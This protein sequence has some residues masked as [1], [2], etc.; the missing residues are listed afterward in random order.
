MAMM[1]V[2][3]GVAL[4]ADAA[5]TTT[6]DDATASAAS[7]KDQ[8][9]LL[10]QK[11]AALARETL[12]RAL[13][14]PSAAE[15]DA[16]TLTNG[17]SSSSSNNNNNNNKNDDDDD[18][19]DKNLSYDGSDLIE[20]INSNGGFIH[21]NARIGLD[22]TGKYRGV[23]VKINNSEKTNENDSERR[24]DEGIEEGDIIARIPW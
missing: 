22:H 1:F 12:A 21:Q 5:T 9:V 23:F 16:D 15:A 19:N 11:S 2:G 4:A 10:F 24:I 20:W 14:P 3:V 6:R 13:G 18:S 17:N 8:L 7:E